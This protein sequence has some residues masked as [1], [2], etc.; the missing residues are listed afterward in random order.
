M[1]NLQNSYNQVVILFDE[2]GT[3]TF[4]EDRE[5]NFLLGVSV[6]YDL[7]AEDFIFDQSRILFGLSNTGALRN[8]K[9][10]NSRAVEISQLLPELPIQIV[11]SILDLSDIEFQ[12]VVNLYRDFGDIMRERYRNVRGRPIAQ[13]L[14]P[15]ILDDCIFNSI[16]D[17]SER[18]QINSSF[19]VF[20][21][22]WSIP[23]NDIEIY[24]E[25]RSR[26]FQEKINSLH[27]EFNYGFEINVAEILL[28][29]QDSYRKRFIGVIA[30]VVSRAF[31]NN[32]NVR[33]SEVPLNNILSSEINQKND[34]TNK[35]KQLLIDVMDDSS[36]NP[37][38]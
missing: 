33:Y 11:I 31:L 38:L 24:L 35:V 26:S 18:N 34:I 25:D 4:R 2:Q 17:Y 6:M 5:T 1:M 19:L 14:H 36:R 37:P 20:I 7:S 8:R 9:I 10:S 12:R 3:P 22:D 30:S 23:V 15:Q 29:N 16:C 27:S 32:D 28:L 21:D 13:I